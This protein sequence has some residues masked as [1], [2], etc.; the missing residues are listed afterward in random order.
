M[1]VKS[2]S[3]K[4]NSFDQLID[5]LF[6][7][8]QDGHVHEHGFTF[9]HNIYG[10]DLGAEE[11]ARKFKENDQYRKK[12]SNG[13][14]AYHE[15]LSFSPEDQESLTRDVMEDITR[16]YIQRRAPDA[17][18]VAKSEFEKDHI[19]IHIAISG[20]NFG[21]KQVTRMSKA[22]FKQLKEDMEQY[23]EKHYPFL[24]SY[25]RSRDAEKYKD[26]N[27][28]R[29]GQKE[30]QMEDRGVKLTKK[31]QREKEVL[32]CFD[33]HDD[34][35]EF[36]VDLKKK[37]YRTYGRN[38]RVEGIYVN[39]GKQRRRFSSLFKN[40]SKEVREK[41]DNFKNDYDKERETIEKIKSWDEENLDFFEPNQDDKDLD[42]G[43]DLEREL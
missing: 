33:A 20:N 43:I 19:H 41:F 6:K 36:V 31:Q 16:E 26:K 4:D 34:L 14:S 35:Y 11:I 3:R 7:E 37:G 29:K 12:R 17:L 22:E 8:E 9:L 18:V 38:G 42:L 28:E 10:N 13:V 21:E 39:G 2:A 23:Q 1:I 30:K 27:I 40:Q 5:Y 24:K 15:I 25:V 32:D